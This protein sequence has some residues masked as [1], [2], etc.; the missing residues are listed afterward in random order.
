MSFTATLP[1]IANLPN[2][3]IFVFCLMHFRF[4]YKQIIIKSNSCSRNLQTAIISSNKDNL[5]LIQYVPFKTDPL[6]QRNQKRILFL[7][8]FGRLNAHSCRRCVK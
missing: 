6:A 8:V 1:V 5:K 7:L 2:V 3:H 4:L